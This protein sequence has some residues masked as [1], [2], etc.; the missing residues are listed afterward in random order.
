V[1]SFLA[2]KNLVS[3]MTTL[4]CGICGGVATPFAQQQGRTFFLEE[5]RPVVVEFVLKL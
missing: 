2:S 4:G 3:G 1:G 5:M